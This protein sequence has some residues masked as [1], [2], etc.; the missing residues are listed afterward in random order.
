MTHL[1]TGSLVSIK[2]KKRNES[3]DDVA[4]FMHERMNLSIRETMSFMLI[5]FSKIWDQGC[6]K[7]L[8]LRGVSTAGSSPCRL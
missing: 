8:V 5:S 1:D 7:H 2:K 6:S 4:K 3:L